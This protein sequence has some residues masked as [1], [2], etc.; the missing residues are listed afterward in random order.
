[1]KSNTNGAGFHR[2]KARNQ[3][4]AISKS[5]LFFHP[6]LLWDLPGDFAPLQNFHFCSLLQ[7]S[8][9]VSRTI[10]YGVQLRSIGG[11]CIS[12]LPSFLVEGW[13]Q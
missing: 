7:E 10:S 2:S 12:D 3:I 6:F 11:G 9:R 13:V 1:M 4:I 5:R 8:L